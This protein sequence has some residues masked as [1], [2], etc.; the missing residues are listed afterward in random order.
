[1][2]VLVLEDDKIAQL[3]IRKI[4][5]N[6]PFSLDLVLLENGRDGLDYLVQNQDDAP[7]MVLLDINM[8]I[9]NGHEFLEELRKNTR[10]QDLPVVVHTTSDNP[11]DLNSCRRLGVMGYFIKHIDYSQYRAN[12]EN[13]MKYW[14]ESKQKGVLVQSISEIKIS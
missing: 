11:S 7:D 13:I 10:W 9:M 1:M 2:K 8:P 4:L 12:L 5:G 3:G 14:A 6:L